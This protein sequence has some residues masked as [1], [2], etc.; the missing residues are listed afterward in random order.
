[1]AAKNTV[2]KKELLEKA[3]G[4]GLKGVSKYR[5]PELIHAIQVAEGNSPCFGKISD[6]WEFNCQF[7]GDCQS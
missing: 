7:G 1:M 5:K 2:T 4:I 6:C 3:S